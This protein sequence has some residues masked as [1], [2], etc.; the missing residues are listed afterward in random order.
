MRLIV[1]GQLFLTTFEPE[2]IEKSFKELILVGQAY[3]NS[4]EAKTVLEGLTKIVSGEISVV[5]MEHSRWIGQSIL[6]PEYPQ[7]KPLVVIGDLEVSTRLGE[8][9]DTLALFGPR[10]KEKAVASR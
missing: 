4:I 3:V 2:Q 10:K 6:G 8:I 1:S 9:P 7:R 5:P